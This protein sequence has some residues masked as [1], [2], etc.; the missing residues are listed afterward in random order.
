[1]NAKNQNSWEQ[2]R[3]YMGLDWAKQE[4]AI[5]VVDGDGRIMTETTIE[6]TA[7]GWHRLRGKLVDLAGP[8][9]SLVAATIET[10]G[11]PMWSVAR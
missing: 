10:N 6:H 2:H 8:D 5:A 11:L 3:Y 7:E 4:H 1:M 9:L